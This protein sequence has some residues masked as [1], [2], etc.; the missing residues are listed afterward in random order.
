MKRLLCF[1]L[2]T[3]TAPVTASQAPR[4]AA[5]V[6]VAR[7]YERILGE[8]VGTSVT[9]LPGQEPATTYFRLVISRPDAGTFRQEFT[10]FRRNR[11]TGVLER[12]G[13]QTTRAILAPDGGVRC[14]AE[15][16]GTILI[17]FKPKKQ[18]WQTSGTG[19]CDGDACFLADV[20]GRVSVDGMPLGLG[21]R[22]KIRKARATLELQGTTLVGRSEV[23]T[24]FRVLLFSKKYRVVT[25]TRAERGRDVHS[26]AAQAA[27]TGQRSVLPAPALYP[28]GC[29]PALVPRERRMASASSAGRCD[30]MSTRRLSRKTS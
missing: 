25:E 26:Y 10:F 30:P 24:R 18:T 19:R 3:L 12:S 6:A 23:E 20:T 2:L 15:A 8:W 13:T 4:E 21:R 11:K 14:V 5:H 9:R 22:G 1:A 7:F 16:S 17:D 27:V 29:A 28:A